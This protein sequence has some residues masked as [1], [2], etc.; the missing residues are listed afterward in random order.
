MSW[1][2]PFRRGRK[3]TIH[4]SGQPQR[5]MH[6]PPTDRLTAATKSAC[7]RARTW[8]S[9]RPIR[10]H[11]H[12]PPQTSS[13][14]PS[15]SCL[16]TCRCSPGGRLPPSGC[17]PHPNPNTWKTPATEP[18]SHDTS[19]IRQRKPTVESKHHTWTSRLS[20]FGI[21]SVL[22]S[23]GSHERTRFHLRRTHCPSPPDI[24]RK[25]IS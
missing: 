8:Q 12:E 1:E 13:A 18:K 25:M 20:Q 15:G 6:S 19:H 17:W 5:R 14:N 4:H 2:N 22:E 9:S 16:P 23:R 3:R 24:C 21:L 10:H 7:R 11:L